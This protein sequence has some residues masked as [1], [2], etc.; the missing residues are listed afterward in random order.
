MQKYEDGNSYDIQEGK[1]VRFKLTDE[2][3]EAIIPG[4][5]TSIGNRVFDRCFW[6]M[7]VFIS[8]GV[9][10]IGHKAFYY[11]WRLTSVEIPDSVTSMGEG[12]FG[13]CS[14]LTN[15]VIPNSVTRFGER[16][17]HGC[18]GLT[19]VTIPGNIT[20]E[21][22]FQDCSK[23]ANVV[24]SDGS[25]SIGDGAFCGYSGLTSVTIPASVTSIGDWAFAGCSGLLSIIIPD[26]VM[27]IGDGAFQDCSG[28][29]SLKIPDNVTSIGEGAFKNCSNLWRM[30][31][32]D[33]V[34]RIG[35]Y[36][37]YDCS[38]L[39]T[40]E[41]PDSVMSI[42]ERV[43]SGCWSLR[44]VVIPMGGARTLLLEKYPELLTKFKNGDAIVAMPDIFM[45]LM[46]GKML[47]REEAFAA[48]GLPSFDSCRLDR[49]IIN[50]SEAF[51]CFERA[52][53]IEASEEA[54]I[55]SKIETTYCVIEYVLRSRGRAIA[56]G[57]D[58]NA[59]NKDV[60]DRIF[61]EAYADK[62]GIKIGESIVK[63]LSDHF[64]TLVRRVLSEGVMNVNV[65]DLCGRAA[66]LCE[67]RKLA[68]L[69]VGDAVV[70]Q[71]KAVEQN[72]VESL[73]GALT[74]QGYKLEDI[75]NID[76]GDPDEFLINGLVNFL[77]KVK[78][79]SQRTVCKLLDDV[80][81]CQ[82]EMRLPSQCILAVFNRDDVP[83]WVKEVVGKLQPN[84]SVV[85]AS[86]FHTPGSGGGGAAA[87][88]KDTLKSGSPS[89]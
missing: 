53:C 38:D 43:F 58:V 22:T 30:K 49:V 7:S 81:K 3:T 31:I 42:G 86:M 32:P 36:A 21:D 33:S 75:F 76:D 68:Y 27:S 41:I 28:L 65:M 19:S 85:Q 29:T 61:I 72:L 80:T 25:I 79:D 88:E 87:K 24:I 55:M 10:S 8:R 4:S 1:V 15:V 57:D 13:R 6:L 70:Y 44:S 45:D 84:S 77:H 74:A 9:T 39:T 20:N 82:K 34:T 46:A 12:V 62:N 47:C 37:F 18:S 51:A 14:K 67:E 17:F 64:E 59:S 83:V 52:Q 78:P 56:Q 60:E 11:C 73:H 35:E 48:R 2:N 71:E 89:I 66:E 40:V 26:S 54:F 5:V 69:C 16:V 23:L 50:A 63:G